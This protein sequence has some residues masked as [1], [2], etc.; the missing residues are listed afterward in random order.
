MKIEVLGFW[1]G[2]PKNGE[3]TS[4]YLITTDAGQI[5]LDCGSGIMSELSLKSNVEQLSAIII[6]HLHHDHIADVGIAQY[7]MVGALRNKRVMNKLELYAPTEPAKICEYIQS[8]QTNFH[9]INNRK[10]IEISGMKISFCKVSHTIPCYAVKIEYN[11][12]SFVY[13][14]DTAYD[15]NLIEFAK[16]VDLFLC[17]ATICEGSTHTIGLGHMDAYEAGEIA[18]LAN[19][20]R[21]VLTHLPHDGDFALMK[22]QAKEI[23]ARKVSLA[24]ENRYFELK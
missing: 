11:G 13:S 8:S 21:L 17:E 23:F 7:A 10:Q 9:S 18:K 2:Y 14:A 6:T 19:V 4:G 22:K 24:N 1:G 16:D 5:L 12:K 3:A 20:K 15:T